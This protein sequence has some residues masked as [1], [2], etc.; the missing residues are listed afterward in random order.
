MKALAYEKGGALL[1]VG[2]KQIAELSGVSLSTVSNVL[3]HKKGVNRQTAELVLKIARDIGY[4]KENCIKKIKLVIYKKHGTVVSDTPF[5]SALIEGVERECRARRFALE[6]CS[7]DRRAKDF[8]EQLN[9]LLQDYTAAILLLA[10][11]LDEE[12]MLPFENAICPVAVLDNWFPSMKFN[13]VLIN[14]TD[15]VFHAVTHLIKCGH[16]R[17]G[18]LKSSVSISNFEY[19]A[20]GYLNAL[21]HVGLKYDASLTVQLTPTMDGAYQDMNS[22]LAGSP[23]LAT[24]YFADNDIIAL[25]AVKAFQQHGIK[26]PEDVSVIG[27]DDMPFCE[28]SSPPL[29]TIRV[30]KH[31]LGALAVKYLVDNLQQSNTVRVKIEVCTDFIQRESVRQI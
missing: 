13:A 16:R 10:T 26:I 8:D 3:N 15:S 19:R 5:F 4:L 24:A 11:E 25:G 1:K 22:Y 21:A 23:E 30:F 2:I 29:T 20:Q 28:I 14:N 9:Y 27:F 18:Y 17:I 6:I 7:L 12:D 31:E